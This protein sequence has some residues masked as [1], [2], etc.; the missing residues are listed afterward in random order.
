ML[1]ITFSGSLEV[2][3]KW[4]SDYKFFS[5]NVYLLKIE[6]FGQVKKCVAIIFSYVSMTW[7]GVFE[8]T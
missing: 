7:V 5:Q 1:L 4:N 3:L 8:T 2:L 6:S